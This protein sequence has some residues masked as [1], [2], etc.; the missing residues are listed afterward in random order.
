MNKG[1]GVSVGQQ[2]RSCMPG[3]EGLVIAAVCKLV[4][5]AEFDMSNL[6]A[7]VPVFPALHTCIVSYVL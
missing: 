2:Q 3:I 1:H 6:S 7:V 5:C 4:C